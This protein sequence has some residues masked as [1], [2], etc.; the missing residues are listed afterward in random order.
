MSGRLPPHTPADLDESQ[1]TVYDSLVASEI[2]WAES[3]GVQAKTSDGCRVQKLRSRC[4]DVLV[5]DTTETIPAQNASVT[6]YR[7]C[8][9]GPC[10][11][12]WREGQR[13]MWPVPVVMIDEHFKG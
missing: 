3:A 4:S 7:R 12:R 8:R 11:L 13:A 6:G 2:P 5:N 10:R 1:R 9:T